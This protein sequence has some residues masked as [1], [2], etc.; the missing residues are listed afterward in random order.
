[1]SERPA[2]LFVCVDNAGHSRRAAGFLVALAG[3]RVDVLSAGSAPRD[4]IN[5]IAAM[6][7]EGIDISTEFPKPW[8]DE[9]VSA[10]AVVITMGCADACPIFPGKR[11]EEWKLADPAGWTLEGVRPVR[12]EIEQR[13]GLLLDVLGVPAQG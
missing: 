11:Y 6:A 3:D 7:E 5:P 13:I 10:A 2:V 12:N 9:V 4:E 8:T 1:M